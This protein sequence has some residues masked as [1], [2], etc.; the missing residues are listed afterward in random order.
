MEKIVTSPARPRVL[1]VDVTDSL[2]SVNVPQVCSDQAV[3]CRAPPTPGDL[4]VDTSV[5]AKRDILMDVILR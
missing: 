3:T 5:P 2:D 1:V 4:T